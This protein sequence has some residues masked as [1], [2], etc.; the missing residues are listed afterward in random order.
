MH[1]L[2]SEIFSS[3]IHSRAGEYAAQLKLIQH[4]LA[5]PGINITKQELP[6]LMYNSNFDLLN[7]DQKPETDVVA[8]IPYQGLMTKGYWWR[9]GAADIADALYKYYADDHV[10]GIM[11]DCDSGGGTLA[12]VIEIE[13]ALAKRNKPVYGFVNS[14]AYSAAFYNCVC[15]TDGAYASNK[16]NGVGS[17]GVMTVI[18]DYSKMMEEMGIKQIEV[19]P[20]E[21]DHKNKAYNEALKGKTEMLIKEMLSP[22]AIGF[23]NAVKAARPKINLEIEGI[24]SGSEFF[25]EDAV[26]Y[27]MI[28]G[29]VS[30]EQMVEIIFSA[31]KTNKKLKSILT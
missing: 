18:T 31:S 10:A 25:A 22:L 14:S 4:Y 9:W 23:Q 13:N 15:H 24:I 27:K 1:N 26:N 7:S 29:I 6:K 2:I 17:I 20:P 19:Y 5:Q 12:A 11:L 30:F 16:K 3:N 28:D 21:S 8:V